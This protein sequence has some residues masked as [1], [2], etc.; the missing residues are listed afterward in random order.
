MLELVRDPKRF[1]HRMPPHGMRTF[2]IVLV[3]QFLLEFLHYLAFQWLARRYPW[4]YFSGT[5][6]PSIEWLY[7]RP[8]ADGL[9]FHW[10][11]NYQVSYLFTILLVALSI[12]IILI[13]YAVRLRPS[14][15]IIHVVD[16]VG[17]SLATYVALNFFVGLCQLIP[18]GSVK[19]FV[20]AVISYALVAYTL[21]LIVTGLAIRLRLR[22]SQAWAVLVLAALTALLVPSG[23]HALVAIV[24]LLV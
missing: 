24:G 22:P 12:T 15:R 9:P 23:L 1:F 6:I 14:L 18:E 3:A 2:L 20:L 10:F 13:P 21:G 4:S 16:V 17:W 7:T 19:Y 8:L 11:V 5:T